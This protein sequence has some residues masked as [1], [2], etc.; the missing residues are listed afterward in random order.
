[1][2]IY[3]SPK[4]AE[5]MASVPTSSDAGSR[6]SDSEKTTANLR[7]RHSATNTFHSGQVASQEPS[8]TSGTAEE[9]PPFSTGCDIQGPFTIRSSGNI[10]QEIL[11]ANGRIIA[12]TTSPWL[13]QV[14]CE[15]LTDFTNKDS[16]GL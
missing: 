10:G 9:R 14:I 6:G 15:L 2:N 8:T 11:D 13:G 1:M 7:P 16:K 3:P 12:W 5:Y 4:L